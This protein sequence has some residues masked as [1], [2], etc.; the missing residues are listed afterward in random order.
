[1]GF[2][3]RRS[4]HAIDKITLLFM[5]GAN[6]G[7]NVRGAAVLCCG[8]TGCIPVASRYNNLIA[9]IRQRSNVK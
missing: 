4:A 7:F 2:G 9:I 5:F 8:V 1:M 3:L 6:G